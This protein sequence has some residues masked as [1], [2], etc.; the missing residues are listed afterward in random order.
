MRFRLSTPWPLDGGAWLAPNGTIIDSTSNDHWSLRA[1][2]LIPPWDATPLD[3]ETYEFM[4]GA[5]PEHRHLMGPRPPTNGGV[6]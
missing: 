1:R 2:G 6:N 5:Y 3:Q 4:Q